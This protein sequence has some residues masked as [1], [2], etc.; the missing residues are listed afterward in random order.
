MKK[1]VLTTILNFLTC[2]GALRWVRQEENSTVLIGYLLRGAD[3]QLISCVMILTPERGRVKVSILADYK[4]EIPTEK[5]VAFLKDAYQRDCWKCWEYSS[6]YHERSPEGTVRRHEYLLIHRPNITM[7]E[8][9][10]STIA[11]VTEYTYY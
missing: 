6:F 9:M 10:I 4:Q 8:E 3:N 1:D 7:N 11:E 2:I 5:Q